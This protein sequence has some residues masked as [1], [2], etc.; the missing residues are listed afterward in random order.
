MKHRSVTKNSFADDHSYAPT[1]SRLPVVVTDVPR[2]G[3][4]VSLRLIQATRRI[5][6]LNTLSRLASCYHM[7]ATA[8]ACS[9]SPLCVDIR[10][11]KETRDSSSTTASTSYG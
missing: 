11:I 2:R 5:S 7:T 10:M 1:L 8:L 6:S 4:S 9:L 3:F